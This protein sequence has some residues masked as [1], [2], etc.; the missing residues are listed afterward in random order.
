MPGHDDVCR[1]VTLAVLARGQSTSVSVFSPCPIEIAFQTFAL[2][3]HRMKYGRREMFL[4][5][6]FLQS[7]VFTTQRCCSQS[8]PTSSAR[9][10][11]VTH[12]E[13]FRVC[14]VTE[15]Y[16]VPRRLTALIYLLTAMLLGCVAS[17][18]VIG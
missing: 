5:V 1:P 3:L 13:T 15:N 11:Y 6:F 18:P 8:R 9:D 17:R 14:C 7:S 2:T 4:A 12:N 16:V 10:C